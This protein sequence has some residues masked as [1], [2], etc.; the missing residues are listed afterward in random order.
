MPYT[1]LGEPTPDPEMMERR[2]Y[3]V[4]IAKV[5][6]NR[7]VRGEGRVQLS[8][9]W[10][11][12]I[13]AWARV[14]APYAGMNRGIYFMPQDGDEV[15]VAFQNGDISAPYVIGSLWSSIDRPP[16]S[17]G[18]ILAPSTKRV[19]R[20]GSAAAHEIVFDDLDSSIT[21]TSLTQQQITM[22]PAQIKL[23]TAG[24]LASITLDTA[25]NISIEGAVSIDL[26][27]Q[28]ISINGTN[29]SVSGT[30]STDISGGAQCSVQAAMV[31]I[32]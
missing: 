30:A 26:Q 17:P 19:I 1:L 25:G 11:P 8:Y 7:D 20:T 5:E 6:T 23:S 3:G 14:A 28:R 9:P 21:V 18:D 10:A 16:I 24:G 22:D 2:V 29:I 4:A 15:L 27:A 32:N 31:R 13:T 12:G